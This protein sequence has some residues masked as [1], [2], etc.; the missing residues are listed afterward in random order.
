M[1]EQTKAAHDAARTLI[2]LSHN[3][4]LARESRT[5]CKLAA[6]EIFRAFGEEQAPDLHQPETG[7]D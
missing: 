3:R 4:Q 5:A 7:Y 1:T 2:A 6:I